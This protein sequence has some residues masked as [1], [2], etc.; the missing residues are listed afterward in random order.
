MSKYPFDKTCEHCFETFVIKNS[1]RQN[2]RFCN[3]RCASEAKRNRFVVRCDN[4]TECGIDISSHKE[5]VKFCSRS[6]STTYYNRLRDKKMFDRISN[7]LREMPVGRVFVRVSRAQIQKTQRLQQLATS[8]QRVRKCGHCNTILADRKKKYCQTCYPNIR[9]Y[10]SLACFKF[11][12]FDFPE[13][14]DLTLVNEYGWFSPNGYKRKNQNPNLG[15]VSRD[16]LFTVADG[17]K[18][19]VDPRIL[20]HPANCKIMIHNGPNGNNS[21]KTSTIDLAELM[22]RIA[23][24]DAKYQVK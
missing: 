2:K 4:C 11:N 9:H 16:H 19:Q 17:F 5:K 21:K 6:C 8:S 13:E 24:W 10:R 20:A 12:V 15:G 7:V 23:T 18:L 22:Q 3:H 1:W 14:F